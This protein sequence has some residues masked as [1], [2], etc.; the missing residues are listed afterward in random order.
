M[1]FLFLTVIGRLLTGLNSQEEKKPLQVVAQMPG[2][3][4]PLLPWDDATGGVLPR[5]CAVL[6]GP[7][8]ICPAEAEVQVVLDG[9][10]SAQFLTLVHGETPIDRIELRLAHP[11]IR[12]C[13]RGGQD[14]VVLLKGDEPCSTSA[15]KAWQYF[16][17]HLKEVPIEGLSCGRPAGC[18]GS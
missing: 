18:G 12:L 1:A 15:A 5:T 17:R 7:S 4:Y 10:E 14:V 2:K 8:G 13:S 9:A 11:R 3:S 16:D 6:P